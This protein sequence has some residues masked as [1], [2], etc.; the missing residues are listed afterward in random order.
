[1]HSRMT[2]TTALLICPIYTVSVSITYICRINTAVIRTLKLTWVACSCNICQ[3][4]SNLIM[5]RIKYEIFQGKFEPS[6]HETLIRFLPQLVSSEPSPQSLSVSQSQ[7]CGMQ[8]WLAQLNWSAWHV[9]GVWVGQS[10]SSLPSKQSLCPSQRQFLGTQRWL[11]QV[12]AE[13]EQV[14]SEG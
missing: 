9:P 13:E 7:V 1:M 6:L 10:C 5:D 11:A 2:L 8:W 4:Q 3:S 12:K 14:L